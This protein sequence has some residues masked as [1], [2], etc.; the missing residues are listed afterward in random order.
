MLAPPELKEVHPLGKSPVIGVQ[1]PGV[2]KPMIIAESGLIVEYLSDYFGQQ[3]IPRR[4]PEGKEGQ[5]GGETEQ[6]LRHRFFM[7]YAEGSLMTL[8]VIT[9]FINRTLDQLAWLLYG[10]SNSLQRSETR[11]SRSS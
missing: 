4:Y 11:P 6:W 7:H 9:I 1:P 2:S 3:L 5:I 10:L 8:M